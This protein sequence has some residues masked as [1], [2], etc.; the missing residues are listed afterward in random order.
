MSTLG[1]VNNISNN[2]PVTVLVL[3]Y[4]YNAHSP[5][6][7]VGECLRYGFLLS[8]AAHLGAGWT[9]GP[10]RALGG[11]LRAFHGLGEALGL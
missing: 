6:V 1:W 2:F 10:S 11:P 4:G 5:P 8:L 7:I 9:P 3:D